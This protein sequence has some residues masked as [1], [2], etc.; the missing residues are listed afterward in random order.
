MAQSLVCVSLFFFSPGATNSK[1][2]VSVYVPLPRKVM[3]QSPGTVEV[4]CVYSM[5]VQMI[6]AS[7]KNR[8]TK[9]FVVGKKR[10]GLQHL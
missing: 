7:T 2:L 4:P 1:I 8:Q 10:G 3:H 5:H 9:Q 6:T